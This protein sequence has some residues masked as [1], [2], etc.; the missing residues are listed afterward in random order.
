M[1]DKK[2]KCPK[3]SASRCIERGTVE[4]LISWPLIYED[5]KLIL[6]DPNIY[7]TSYKCLACGQE[8]DVIRKEGQDPKIVIREN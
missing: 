7:T 4:T 2:V 3:C 5:D 1:T 8:F 6:I